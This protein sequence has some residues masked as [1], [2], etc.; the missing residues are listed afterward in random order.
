MSKHFSNME[1]A[2]AEMHQYGWRKIKNGR[3]VSSDG[4]CA[5]HILGTETEVV[6]LQVWAI[7]TI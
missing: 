5:A 2:V 4:T 1:S 6:L 3:W 7:G